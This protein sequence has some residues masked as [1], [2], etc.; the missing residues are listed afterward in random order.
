M[1]RF[2]SSDFGM[3]RV[4]GYNCSDPGEVTFDYVN[5]WKGGNNFIDDQAIKHAMCKRTCHKCDRST[6][7]KHDMRTSSEPRSFTFVRDPW[8]HFVSGYREATFQIYNHCCEHGEL[9]DRLYRR[10]CASRDAAHCGTTPP[11]R[12][13]TPSSR[14]LTV[15]PSV[16]SSD[17]GRS[18]TL[19]QNTTVRSRESFACTGPRSTI[20][21]YVLLKHFIILVN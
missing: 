18:G 7:V 8:S 10:S 6:L 17:G 5:V 3:T 9:K 19:R 16:S 11:R 20:H 2:Y 21:T 4:R 12:R 13:A 15:L 14:Y 1:A